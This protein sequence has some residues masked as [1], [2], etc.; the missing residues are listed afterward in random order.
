MA[1]PILIENE[2]EQGARHE[3]ICLGCM[4]GKDIGLLTC[5][6]CWSGRGEKSYKYYTGSL[7]QW[8][9]EIE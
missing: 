2:F 9:K 5:W 1:V 7:E 4:K 3:T 6:T 8:L